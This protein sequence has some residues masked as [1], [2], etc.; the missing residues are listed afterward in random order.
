LKLR[1]HVTIPFFLVA[2]SLLISCSDMSSIRQ[3]YPIKPVREYERMIVG[4]LDAD[5]VGNAACLEKCHVNGHDKLYRDFQASVHASQIDAD[6]GLPLVNCESC[7]GPGSLAIIDVQ[8][9][10]KPCKNETLLDLESMPK[11][12]QSLICL[13]CHSAAST[14]ALQFWNASPHATSEVSCFDCHKLHMGAQQ[15]V[16]RE[17]TSELCYDCHLEKK[18][19]FANFSHHPVPEG[20]VVCIDCHNPHGTANDAQ[21]LGATVKATCTK[22]HMEYMG[23]FVYEHSDVTE[24]CSNCHKPHGSPN[25]PLLQVAQPFLCMQ[26]HSG[27]HGAR[28]DMGTLSSESMKQAFFNRCT[29]CH[30]AIHGTD[31]P[32]SHGRGTFVA[33]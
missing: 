17:E 7:H 25:E 9:N 30:S 23:P 15:K 5:Y 31:I 33:R 19:E 4:R 13:K 2:V 11:M 24:N 3:D 21:L 18:M 14:P 29:D 26:C 27:H 28:S 22:C 20:K 8:D 10:G 6:S 12:A 1:F 32:T 16:S